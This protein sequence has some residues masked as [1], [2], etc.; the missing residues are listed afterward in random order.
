MGTLFLGLFGWAWRQIERI[1][2]EAAMAYGSRNGRPRTD[3]SSENLNFDMRH[4]D[5]K[6]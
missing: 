6:T 5:E 3:V 2:R 4:V 1:R